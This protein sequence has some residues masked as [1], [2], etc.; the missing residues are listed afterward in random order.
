MGVVMW[1]NNAKT[2]GSVTPIGIGVVL[3]Y[4]IERKVLLPVGIKETNRADGPAF[5]R[6]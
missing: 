6:F 5:Y 2:S 1:A 3:D 4:P